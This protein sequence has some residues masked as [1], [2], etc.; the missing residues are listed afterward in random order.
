M[1]FFFSDQQKIWRKEDQFGVKTFFSSF[2]GDQQ[3]TWRKVDH[4][5]NFGTIPK[6]LPPQNEILPPL[7]QRSCCD[8]AVLEQ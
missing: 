1:T 3:K 2:F 6:I 7:K 4:P 5:K 8:T